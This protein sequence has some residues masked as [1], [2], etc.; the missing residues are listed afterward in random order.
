MS[1]Y[2]LLIN[3]GLWDGDRVFTST[4]EIKQ[5]FNEEVGVTSLLVDREDEELSLDDGIERMLDA[6]NM[7][8]GLNVY[9][10]EFCEM[11]DD[12]ADMSI[13]KLKE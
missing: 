13:C 6:G 11:G 8:E 7:G 5:L 3:G 9:N 10:E 4:D 1:R 2:V 12:H